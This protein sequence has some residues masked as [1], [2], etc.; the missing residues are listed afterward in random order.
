MIPSIVTE[1]KLT[2]TQIDAVRK[3]EET[4]SPAVAADVLAK[5]ETISRILAKGD[6]IDEKTAVEF[7][8]AKKF[9]ANDPMKGPLTAVMRDF[10]PDRVFMMQI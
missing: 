7:D 2:Q 6:S 5:L 3:E 9:M 8:Q 4:T 1:P 10:G